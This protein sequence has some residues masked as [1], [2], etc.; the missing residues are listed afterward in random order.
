MKILGVLV[1]PA[2]SGYAMVSPHDPKQ[3][4]VPSTSWCLRW[5]WHHRPVHGVEAWRFA[6]SP[7]T[8]KIDPQRRA[9]SSQAFVPSEQVDLSDLCGFITKH[10]RIVKGG[11]W[12]S[13]SIQTTIY[14]LLTG[15]QVYTVNHLTTWAMFDSS[16]IS[17]TAAQ[18]APSLVYLTS[19]NWAPKP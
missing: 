12:F 8:W 2:T 18:R 13:R 16:S 4:P 6:S 3:P 10:A 7:G 9:G 1:Y 19:S 14:H 17:T 5:A 11:H 15:I